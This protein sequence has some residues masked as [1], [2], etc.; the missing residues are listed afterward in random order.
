M[1]KCVF[2]QTL[3]IVPKN[4]INRP[5]W[6]LWFLKSTCTPCIFPRT[7][8]L[9][10]YGWLMSVQRFTKSPLCNQD[11]GYKIDGRCSRKTSKHQKSLFRH[12]YSQYLALNSNCFF[13]T[14]HTS[15]VCSEVLEVHSYFQNMI[16]NNK[17]CCK[18]SHCV[19]ISSRYHT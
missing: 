12:L 18:P 9:R 1:G 10:S 3:F 16:Q 5:V 15:N 4:F 14:P 17:V 11:I 2:Q 6:T 8:S 7:W 13:T 19:H